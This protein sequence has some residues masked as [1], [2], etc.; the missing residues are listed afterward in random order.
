MALT[1]NIRASRR[2]LNHIPYSV[3]IEELSDSAMEV[4]KEDKAGLRKFNQEVKQWSE[5]SKV[6]LRRSVKSLI[7]QDVSLSDSIRAKVYYNNKYGKE[8]NRVGFSF[9]RE[10]IFIHKGARRGRGG[11][12]GSSWIDRHGT[13]KFRDPMSA[14]KQ[15]GGIEWFDPVIEKRIPQLA[16]IVAE[17]SILLQLNAANLFIDK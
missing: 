14:G 6:A 1:D 13:R 17:H 7:K 16:D 12:I 11:Y 5:Q 3:S 10:G 8:A 9:A 2:S 15:Y 4:R